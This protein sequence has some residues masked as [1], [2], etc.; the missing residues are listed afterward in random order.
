ML[1][2]YD[3]LPVLLLANALFFSLGALSAAA[4]CCCSGG[5][6]CGVWKK[7]HKKHNFDP[8][9][10]LYYPHPPGGGEKALL[11]QSFI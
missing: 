11:H 10:T 1:K 5:C 4:G 9:L 2:L 8:I 6:G 7:T 3:V